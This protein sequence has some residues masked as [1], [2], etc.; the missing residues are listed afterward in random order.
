[1]LVELF[2]N[3]GAL[4]NL[5]AFVSDNAARNYKVTPPETT[6]TLVNEPMDVPDLI[7]GVVPYKAGESVSWKVTQKVTG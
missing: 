4:D 7:S 6:V 1:M 3:H 2:H 5:Q